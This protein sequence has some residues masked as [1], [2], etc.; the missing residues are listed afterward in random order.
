MRC[1]VQITKLPIMESS[2]D[3]WRNTR[4]VTWGEWL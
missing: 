1:N 3:T 2:H 4:E